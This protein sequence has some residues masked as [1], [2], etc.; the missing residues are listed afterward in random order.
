MT[1]RDRR[2]T[3]EEI[4]KLL[5]IEEFNTLTCAFGAFSAKRQEALMNVITRAWT[6]GYKKGLYRG[7]EMLADAVTSRAES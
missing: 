7:A 3:S 5:T 4:E 6:E 1:S 2:L